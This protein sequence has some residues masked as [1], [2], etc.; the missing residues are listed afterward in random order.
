MNIL[1]QWLHT[2]LLMDM[3]SALFAFVLDLTTGD[4]AV[5]LARIESSFVQ[6]C[7]SPNV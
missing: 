5:I 2:Q 4:F 6:G 3:Y 1:L 7:W